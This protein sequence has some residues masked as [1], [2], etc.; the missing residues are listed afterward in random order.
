M[1]AFHRPKNAFEESRCFR[2]VN[3]TMIPSTYVW[4][5]I[6]GW[7]MLNRRHAVEIIQMEKIAGADLVPAWGKGQWHESGTG[8]WAP[9]EVYFPTMLALLGYLRDS[10]ESNGSDQVMRRKVTYAEFA[11]R[12][13]AN[14]IT[15]TELNAS[16]LRKF[17][18]NTNN[19]YE[20]GSVFARKFAGSVSLNR[21]K[22]LIINNDHD[23]GIDKK[24]KI[25]D[26]STS[27]KD[28]ANDDVN[29]LVYEKRQ[30]N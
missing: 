3:D 6:P 24:R 7:M 17:R 27:N 4:K 22:Q 20:Q 1:N 30:K 15:Y 13:D 21:W 8:V 16:L 18:G 14:P 11:K 2:A 28:N 5:C 10:G 9:E 25:N 12:G 29:K 19:N 26:S 23:N